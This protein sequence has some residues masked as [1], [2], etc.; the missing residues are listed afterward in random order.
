[1]TDKEFENYINHCKRDVTKAFNMGKKY[2]LLKFTQ[3]NPDMG[4]FKLLFE[5]KAKL[6]LAKKLR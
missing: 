4:K 3:D 1:M 6:Y 2:Y 5:E